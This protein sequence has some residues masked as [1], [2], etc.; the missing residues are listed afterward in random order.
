MQGS[1]GRRARRQEGV[2]CQGADGTALETFEGGTAVFVFGHNSRGDG[3]EV[4]TMY[5]R[6]PDQ[7][8]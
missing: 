5:P 7:E 3:Y 8:R 2:W 1:L 6:P 4:V